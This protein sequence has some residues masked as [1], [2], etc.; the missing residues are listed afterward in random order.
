MKNILTVLLLIVISVGIGLYL[1]PTP[2]L[3]SNKNQGEV[4]IGG[5]FSLIDQ[6]GKQTQDRDFRGKLMLVFFGFTNCPNIC[7]T[8]LFI[9]SE[10]MKLLGEDSKDV[11]PLFI[12]IDPERDTSEVLANYLN[13]FSKSLIGLTGTTAQIEQVTSNY[14]IYYA[15][16][17]DQNSSLEYTMD[18]STFTYL[19]DKNGKYITHFAHNTNAQEMSNTIRKHLK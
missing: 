18:H 8:D 3:S 14:R 10:A 2:Q 12:T 7:P 17:K 6:H 9:M 5:D 19:M 1:M 15:K 4:L 11:A 16:A 13:N